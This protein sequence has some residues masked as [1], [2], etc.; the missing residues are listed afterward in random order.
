MDKTQIKK[1]I[2]GIS[3]LLGSNPELLATELSA[4]LPPVFRPRLS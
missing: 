2:S 4:S 1:A 3:K